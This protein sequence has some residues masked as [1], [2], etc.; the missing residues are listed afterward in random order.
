MAYKRQPSKGV[1]A[2]DR[3]IPKNNKFAHIQ[4]SLDTGTNVNKVKTVTARE[5]AKRR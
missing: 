4:S 3:A 1:S 2:M 5:Y